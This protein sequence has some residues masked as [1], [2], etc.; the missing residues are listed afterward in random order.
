MT[1]RDLALE[2]WV[3]E[4][5]FDL[6]WVYKLIDVLSSGFQNDIVHNIANCL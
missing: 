6:V 2:E 4:I 1:R 5:Q 3:N